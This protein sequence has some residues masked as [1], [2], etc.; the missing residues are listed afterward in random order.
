MTERADV[1]AGIQAGADRSPAS[2][3]PLLAT[4]SPRR[5]ARQG[6]LAGLAL[7]VLAAAVLLA[8]RFERVR[9]L[10]RVIAAAARVSRRLVG[11]PAQGVD[12]LEEFLERV[13]S[14]RLP[15]LRYA[16]VFSL[17]LLNWAADCGALACAIRA[18][19]EPVPWHS[20][21]L[22]YAAGAAPDEPSAGP[23]AGRRG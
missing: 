3:D 8:L 10:H 22:V 4:D 5:V 11:V 1:P 13:A 2:A 15:G 6:L 21:L 20:L 18:T 12:G 7:A 17:A 14:L 19:G 23:S 9:L 16:E